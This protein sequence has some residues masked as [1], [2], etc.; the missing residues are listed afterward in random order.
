MLFNMVNLVANIFLTLSGASQ[1]DKYVN[2]NLSIPITI[3][4]D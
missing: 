1:A 3:G 2:L 4:T